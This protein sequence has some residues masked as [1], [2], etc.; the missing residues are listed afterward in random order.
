MPT[1]VQ[2]R[3]NQVQHTTQTSKAGKELNYVEITGFDAAAGKGFKKRFFATKKDGTATKNA[4]IADALSNNDWVELVLDDSSFHNVQTVKKI[5][6]PA[7]M[8]AP[9]QSTGSASTGPEKEVNKEAWAKN[10][11]AKTTKAFRSTGQLNREKALDSAIKFNNG[12]SQ[13][14]DAVINIAERFESYLIGQP[15]DGEARAQKTATVISAEAGQ[16]KLDAEAAARG[17]YANQP[18]DDDIP[19]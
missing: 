17:G 19:F 6:E 7:G 3:V 10:A 4:E 11:P 16:A 8:T 14:V 2:V 9:D 18:Q 12:M 15:V 5:A 13:D 1:T